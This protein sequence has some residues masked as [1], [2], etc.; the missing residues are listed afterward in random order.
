MSAH[1]ALAPFDETITIDQLTRDPYPIYKRLRAQS[2]V[3]RVG[4]VGRTFLTKAADTKR[5]KEDPVTFSSD[6]P[7]T[8][9]KRAFQATTLMR[10]DGKEHMRERMAMMSALMPKTIVEVWQPLYR[11]IVAEYL[12]RLPRGEIVDFHK[13]I[14]DPVAARILAHILGIPEASDS[15][16]QRWSQTLIDGAGNFGNQPEPFA[17]SDQTNAEMNKV[18]EA[19]TERLR[20]D[21]DRSA[22]S[23]MVNAEDPIPYSQI[24]A[25]IKIAVGGGINEPRDALSTIL[26]GLLSNPDQL[27]AVKEQEKWGAAFEEG[28]RWCAPIQV[29][30]RRV[31][32]DTE[33]GGCLVPQGD[34]V[35]TIQASANHDEDLFE[36][37]EKFDS[38]RPAN[39]H[40]SFGGG[41]HHC[42]GTHVSRRT[43]GQIML[44]MLFERFPSIELPDPSLVKWRGFG[45]RGPINLPLRLA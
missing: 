16:M 22:L 39:L 5:V 21:P 2:P 32:Q 36:Q 10:K 24:V 45:F 28:V 29:S 19:A 41:P 44:P 33:I 6:D 38:F 37:P 23:V 43:V 4:S 27:E 11:E 35:M 13:E 30:S 7:Q 12:D 25:N 3:L 1:P 26:V 8:P 34:V 18:L 40:Q 15:Q 42:A 31:T 9:M 14:S 20:K 17:A